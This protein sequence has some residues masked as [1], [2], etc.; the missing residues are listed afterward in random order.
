MLILVTR[1]VVLLSSSY[2]NLLVHAEGATQPI[3]RHS[4]HLGG[5]VRGHFHGGAELKA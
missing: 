4:G 2:T 5:V 3:G 1:G